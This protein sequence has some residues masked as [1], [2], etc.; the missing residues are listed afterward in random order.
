MDPNAHYQLDRDATQ[1]RSEVAA[2]T[3][4][5]PSASASFELGISRS[6]VQTQ[7]VNGRKGPCSSIRNL[8]RELRPFILMLD[9]G[10]GFISLYKKGQI[11][12]PIVPCEQC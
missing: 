10:T 11:R 1:Q 2:Q 12:A 3:K 6:T 9:N 7:T 4:K 5:V 8:M